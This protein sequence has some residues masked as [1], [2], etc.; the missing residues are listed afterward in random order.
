[1]SANSVAKCYLRFCS[2]VSISLAI[3]SCNLDLNTT[4]WQTSQDIQTSKNDS[5]FVAQFYPEINADSLF[6]INE[7]WIEFL[8]KNAIV[9]GKPIILKTDTLQLDFTIS[10]FNSN[11]FTHDTYLINWEMMVNDQPVGQNTRVYS[12]VLVKLNIQK[13]LDVVVYL[14]KGTERIKYSEFKIRPNM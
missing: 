14:L 1:M 7:A 10:K 12:V 8:W 11:I 6:K 9:N 13:D 4:D 3:S 5:L 2:I